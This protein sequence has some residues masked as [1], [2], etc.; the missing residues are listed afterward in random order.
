MTSEHVVL[1][2]VIPT[3]NRKE[4]L[5]KCVSSIMD[6]VHMIGISNEIIVVDDCSTDGTAEMIETNFPGIII[7]RHE[8]NMLLCRTLFDGF[9]KARGNYILK[10]DD[11]NTILPGAIANLL[12]FFNS[13]QDLGFCGAF[14]FSADGKVSTNVGRNYSRFLIRSLNPEFKKKN[15]NRIEPYEV[16][17]V[18]NVYMFKRDSVDL[19]KFASACNLFPRMYQDEYTQVMMRRQGLRIMVIPDSKVI[20]KNLT[21]KPDYN[22]AYYYMRSKIVWLRYLQGIRGVRLIIL[23]LIYLTFSIIRSL[24]VVKPQVMDMTYV[25]TAINGTRDGFKFIRNVNKKLLEE[26]GLT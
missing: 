11:D 5:K 19:E 8:S 6:E 21:K 15:K 14:A 1:S 12:G 4:S 17:S 3:F 23:A 24:F 13:H 22:R 25:K 9:K 2:I 20:H 26:L 18:D 16:E 10:V 7:L